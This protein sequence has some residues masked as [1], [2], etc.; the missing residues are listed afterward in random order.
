MIIRKLKAVLDGVGATHD[1]I[2]CGL[3]AH[4]MN[5]NGQPRLAPNY[6]CD[7]IDWV[8]EH[9]FSA[10]DDR[11]VLRPIV[12]N[13]FVKV[14]RQ[15]N[16]TET[17]RNPLPYCYIQDLRQILCP[18][19]RQAELKQIEQGLKAGETL[20]PPYHYRHFTHWTWAQQQTGHGTQGGDWFEVEPELID[21]IT[22]HLKLL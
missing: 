18:L 14:K 5:G 6:T 21:K 20:L 13:P 3:A 4:D 9:H 17:V 1:D 10:E 11:G 7:F 8:L 22:G 15:N 2:P 19:P 12:T 16:L